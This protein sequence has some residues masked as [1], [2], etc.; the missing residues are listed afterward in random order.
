VTTYDAI[1]SHRAITLL[2]QGH[3]NP[4]VAKTAISLLRYR[5]NDVCAVLDD[6]ATHKTAQDVFNTG[7][8]T[9]IVA[10]LSDIPSSDSLYIGIA[11]P[12]GKL[13]PQWKPLILAAIA[14]K[15]DIVSGLHDFLNDDADYVVAASK[16]GSTLIDVRANKFKDIASGQPLS[17]DCTRIHSVGHDCSVGKMVATIEINRGLNQ[18]GLNAQFLATGQTGIMISGS[19]IPIDCVVSDFVNGAAEHLVRTNQDHDFVLIEG[20]GS[21]SHPAYSAVTL[22]LLHGCA[23]DALI[24]CYEA[25]RNQVKGLKNIDIPSIDKQMQAFIVNA[26]LRHP[27]KFIGIAVNTRN[28]T[29][30]HANAEIEQIEQRFNLPACDVYRDGSDKLVDACIAMKQKVKIE[31]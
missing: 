14:R 20:Q 15:M 29:P 11:P 4:F 3:S 12:G 8:T 27:C 25:G 7:G 24:F 31:A 16:S 1:R 28:L 9:P 30:A 18:R 23:P 13:P 21:I 2:T 10:E 19:G 26:N 6:Q 17:G 5:R 22:G